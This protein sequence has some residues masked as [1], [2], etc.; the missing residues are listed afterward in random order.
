MQDAAR[1]KNQET[2]FQFKND[3]LNNN[4]LRS[5]CF[6]LNVSYIVFSENRFVNDFRHSGLKEFE[7]FKVTKNGF[8]NTD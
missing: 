3:M 2:I 7:V 4:E 5:L 8:V 6:D 1:L